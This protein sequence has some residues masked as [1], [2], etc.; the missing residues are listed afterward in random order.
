MNAFDDSDESIED[1]ENIEDKE[2]VWGL[3]YEDE[4]IFW[5]INLINKYIY[6]PNI[7]LC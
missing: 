5:E 1:D 7:C 2:N 6:S 4:K 3:N